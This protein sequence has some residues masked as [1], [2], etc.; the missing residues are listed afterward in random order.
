MKDQQAAG[1]ELAERAVALSR[2]RGA[3][4]AEA[5]V[6]QQS[7]RAAGVFDGQVQLSGESRTARVTVRLFRDNRGVVVLGHGSSEN[8]LETLIAQALDMLPRTSADKYFGPA[9]SDG[10][11]SCDAELGIYDERLARL[12]LQGVEGLALDAEAAVRRLDGRLEHLVTAGV[13]VQTQSVALHSSQGFSRDYRA[14]SAT[15]TLNAVV[16]GSVVDVGLAESARDRQ[17][18]MAAATVLTR[19]LGRLNV[20]RAAERAVGRLRSMAD[21]RPCPAGE[22]PVVFSPT[23]A[24]NL[25][26]LLLQVCSGPATIQLE[27]TFLGK[28]GDLV[29]SPLLTLVDD[30]TLAGGVGTALFDHEGVSPRRKVIIERGVLRE[31]LLNS[32]YARALQRQSTGNAVASADARFGVRPSNAFFEA[33]GASPEDILASVRRGFYVNRFLSY[34][35]PLAANFTQAAEGFWVEDGRLAHPVRAAALSAPLQGMLKSVV[36]VGNDLDAQG[37]VYS[38]TLLVS[39]MNVSPLA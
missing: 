39:K 5:L 35:M 11:G 33:G 18:L 17:N 31:Y 2:K 27:S 37:A 7:E 16:D 9:D 22:V 34:S 6:V 15:L 12:P 4:Q 14:S 26:S 30:A 19:S 28:L 13:Q 29:C 32:Y 10:L 8:M 1:K 21:A 24:R 20:E 23:A 36:A 25:A 38:P 3:E